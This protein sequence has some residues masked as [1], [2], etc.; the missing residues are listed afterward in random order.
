[1]ALLT[2]QSQLV[3]RGNGMESMDLKHVKLILRLFPFNGVMD[4]KLI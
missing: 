3:G 4:K 2:A 1:M